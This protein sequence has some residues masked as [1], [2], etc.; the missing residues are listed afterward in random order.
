MIKNKNQLKNRIKEN[1]ESIKIK[2]IYNIAK[3]NK[4]SEGSIASIEKV[5]TNAFTIKYDNIA[6]DVWIYYDNIDVEDNKIIYYG[7]IAD[8]NK[9]AAEKEAAEK[10]I[11]LINV[12][13]ED[14]INK[15]NYSNY[16][17]VYKYITIINEIIEEG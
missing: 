10:H 15:N 12:N 4:I 17:Y 11:T 3:N 2:R 8:Y 13:P 14:K 6:K 7:Y 9:E 5:Q 1:K 16:K